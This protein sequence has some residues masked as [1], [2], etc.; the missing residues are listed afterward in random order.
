MAV[1]VT[2]GRLVWADATQGASAS[3]A[4]QAKG[5][6]ERTGVEAEE[7]IVS[8]KKR[9]SA[10]VRRPMECRC[11]GLP[12]EACGAAH[13]RSA[14]GAA[15]GHVAQGCGQAR[16]KKSGP[17]GLS[18]LQVARVM[19]VAHRPG[20]CCAQVAAVRAPRKQPCWAAVGARAW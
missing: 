7:G 18:A 12:T 9:G 13:V 10:M 17:G 6:R 8:S 1:T 2:S 19:A 5:G 16:D 11:T 20:G 15:Q 14:A 3:G 4:S